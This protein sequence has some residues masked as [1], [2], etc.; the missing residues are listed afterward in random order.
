MG[1]TCLSKGHAGLGSIALS[2]SVYRHLEVA[3]HARVRL[4]ILL[5]ER[6]KTCVPTEESLAYWDS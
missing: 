6:Q 2:P 4:T 5:L 3:A 1:W